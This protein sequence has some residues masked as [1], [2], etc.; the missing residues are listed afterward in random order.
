MPGMISFR[1]AMV[2]ALCLALLGVP[3]C[4]GGGGSG[5]S[6]GGGTQGFT[7]TLT[8]RGTNSAETSSFAFGNSLA[9]DVRIT[10]RSGGTQVLTLPTSQIYDLGLFDLG[11]QTPRWRWSFNQAFTPAATNLSF[12]GHQSINYLYVWPGVLEDGTQIMPGTYEVRAI[13]AYPQYSNDWRANDEWATP[14]KR[15]TITD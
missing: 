15:I 7:V 12:A 13:L 3:G 6:S 9:F 4:G 11:S 10:N 1:L 14:F 2:G 5:G 8:M